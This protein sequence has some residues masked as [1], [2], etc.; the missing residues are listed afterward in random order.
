MFHHPRLFLSVCAGLALSITS[1]RASWWI[2][3]EGGRASA[4]SNVVAIPRDDGTRFSLT[5]DFRSDA[6]AYGRLRVGVDLTTRSR[7]SFLLAPLALD[8]V[9][10]L[11][12]PLTFEG[13]TFGAGTPLGARYRFNSYRLTWAR[14]F[15]D[16]PRWTLSAGV[17]AKIR[18]AE[19]MVRGGGLAAKKSNVGFVP[20]L[21]GR[22]AGPVAGPI[23][24]LL[25]ADALAAPQGR[26]EDLFAGLTWS[27]APHLAARA[28]YRLLEGGADVKSV[29]N[30][31]WIDYWGAGVSYR[32]GVK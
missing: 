24:L 29:Y 26:A 30:F 22:L 32:F 20:L 4:A 3:L 21:H 11:D 31:A 13:V 19:I 18:D 15:I 25:E 27:P 1:A 9:G 6:D 28:G 5:D 2:D 17:T 7:L 12:R 14:D 23:G 10:T 8:A 16:G